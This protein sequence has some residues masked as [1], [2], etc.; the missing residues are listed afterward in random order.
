[1]FCIFSSSKTNFPEFIALFDKVLSINPCPKQLAM[2][3]SDVFDH[4]TDTISTI[5]SY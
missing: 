5:L 1:M 2:V 4:A 3:D